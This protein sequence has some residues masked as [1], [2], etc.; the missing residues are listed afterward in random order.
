MQSEETRLHLHDAHQRVMSV[1]AVQQQLQAS[2]HGEL[3]ELGP[4]LIRLC[5]ALAASMIGDTRPIALKVDAEGGTASTSDATSI[6]LIVTELVINALKHAFLHD[7]PDA[8][9]TVTYEVKRAGGWR[10]DNEMAKPG[11]WSAAARSWYQHVD[12]LSRQLGGQVEVSRGPQG[13]GSD[14][15][16]AAGAGPAA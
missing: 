6:G 9:I 5:E 10:F 16:N 2:R 15:Q 12:A 1:A 4:Y 7:Q 8:R 11:C 13:A 3:I 14:R